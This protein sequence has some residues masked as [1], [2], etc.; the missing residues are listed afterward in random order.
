M[1][2][3]NQGQQKERYN[4]DNIDT[5]PIITADTKAPTDEGYE[6]ADPTAQTPSKQGEDETTREEGTPAPDAL[7]EKGPHPA[8]QQR[9]APDEKGPAPRAMSLEDTPRL[10]DKQEDDTV[11]DT[12][13]RAN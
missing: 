1:E 10:Q 8:P 7:V 6:R 12:R 3:S 9:K 5:P 2:D 13:L 11:K 4:N